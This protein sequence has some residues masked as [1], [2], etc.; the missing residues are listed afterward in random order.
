MATTGSLVVNILGNS[1]QL[2]QELHQSVTKTSSWVGQMKSL[3][4]SVVIAGAGLLGLG[5][6]GSSVAWGVE[7]AAQAET[8][9]I[10]FEVMLGSAA[11]AKTVLADLSQFA[12]ETPFDSPELTD[13]ARKLVA[14]GTGAKELIPTLRTIGDISAGIGAPISEIAELYGKAQ[15]QGRL[16]MEDINQ[17][18][19]RG[20]PIIQEL[21]KQ[22]GVTDG[23]VRKLVESGRVNFG[24][25][26]R[27]FK[28]LTKEG[29]TF[30]GLMSKQSA[31]LAGLWS[32]LKDNLGLTM[33][34]IGEILIEGFDF[35]SLLSGTVAFLDGLLAFFKAYHHQVKVIAVAM[36]VF[37]GTVA[38]VTSAIIAYAAAMRAASIVGA[39][40]QGILNP[41]SLVKA[42]AGLAVAAG[43]VAALDL[44]LSRA[45]AST[46]QLTA[47]VQGLKQE[48]GN[49]ANGQG[50]ISQGPDLSPVLKQLADIQL[51]RD[52]LGDQTWGADQQADV[53]AP[54]Q[55]QLTKTQAQAQHLAD[56]LRKVKERANAVGQAPL[57]V[58]AQNLERQIGEVTGITK[59]IETARRALAIANGGLRT[60]DSL[61][62]QGF[63]EA[64]ATRDQ[65]RELEQLQQQL[66]RAKEQNEALKRTAELRVEGLDAITNL[67][68]ELDKL[69][70][71]ATETD[72]A[73]RDLQRRGIDPQ[74]LQQIAGLMKQRDELKEIAKLKERAEEIAKATRTPEQ[75]LADDLKE[76][77]DL[78][79]KGLITAD[80]YAQA[81]KQAGGSTPDAGKAN[82]VA[83]DGSQNAVASILRAAGGRNPSKVLEQKA[84]LQIQAINDTNVLLAEINRKPSPMGTD[85][86]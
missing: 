49:D 71:V 25:L 2:Q 4:G 35:K 79:A 3:L 20:I 57:G 23:E 14:F 81:V 15:V 52:T 17:L 11:T 67:T 73:L 56:E 51:L 83:L 13:A 10:S 41:A 74:Q 5:S 62:L 7:L 43:I 85:L 47:K 45:G 72:L 19:G 36:S 26:E 8:A 64:G 21:A 78:R 61:T 29:G 28:D 70:G 44:S 76:L 68:D 9:Q 16:F 53:L 80:V 75:K 63:A 60:E 82:A 22:F 77:E 42:A 32:T 37:G 84:D 55:K 34:E 1:M 58:L 66:A 86:A 31:S 27:A 6:L 38:F 50:G 54:F 24:H 12:A 30:G 46:D 33:R 39:Y 65:I 69:S 18:T 48:I 40:F 59:A